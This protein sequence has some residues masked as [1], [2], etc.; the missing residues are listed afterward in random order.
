MVKI[1]D[2]IIR[3]AYNCARTGNF[4]QVIAISINL[5]IKELEIVMKQG[6][7][8]LEDSVLLSNAK[9]DFA[10]LYEAIIQGESENEQGLVDYIENAGTSDWKAA[11]W[12]LERRYSERWQA[13]KDDNANKDKVINVSFADG[14]NFYK[15]Q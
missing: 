3:T 2:K 11:S 8:D 12:L 15:N 7:K 1:T 5:S 4:R 13:K 9:T 10:K 14:I 6:E